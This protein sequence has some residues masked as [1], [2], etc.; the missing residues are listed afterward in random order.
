M[1]IKLLKTSSKEK[2]LNTDGGKHYVQR[3]Q[4]K[5]DNRLLI[6]KLEENGRYEILPS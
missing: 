3:N 5:N 6:R 1:K 2:I 4:D